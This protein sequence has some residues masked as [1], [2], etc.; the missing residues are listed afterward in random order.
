[1][2]CYAKCKSS[3]GGGPR[4]AVARVVGDEGVGQEGGGGGRERGRGAGREGEGKGKPKAI[5]S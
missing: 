4:E 5:T 1:M 2:L 3:A